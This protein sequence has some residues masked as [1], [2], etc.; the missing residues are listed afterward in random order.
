MATMIRE[1]KKKTLMFPTQSRARRGMQFQL[2]PLPQEH[3]AETSPP[4]PG[5]TSKSLH[6]T[7]IKQE[8]DAVP[9]SSTDPSSSCWAQTLGAW[10]FWWAESCCAC[11]EIEPGS[12]SL[13]SVLSSR[14]FRHKP[15][16]RSQLYD[17]LLGRWPPNACMGWPI[18]TLSVAFYCVQ[19]KFSIFKS[20]HVHTPPFRGNYE[21]KT[22]R[23]I[24]KALEFY[25][26][27][28]DSTPRGQQEGSTDCI[29]SVPML[30]TYINLVELLHAG[31]TNRCDHAGLRSLPWCSD[32]TCSE[33]KKMKKY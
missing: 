26:N 5:F 23:S 32:C 30:G 21:G 9:G 33:K 6:R 28:L 24:C 15:S 4:N 17:L 18:M 10:W 27:S 1:R 13:P 19:K 22:T 31:L 29:R 11:T 16:H 25:L 7:L 12:C 2:S 8:Q 20:W 3:P 14:N